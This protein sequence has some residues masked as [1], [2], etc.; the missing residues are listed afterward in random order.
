MLSLPGSGPPEWLES[1]DA[2]DDLIVSGLAWV[3]AGF[4]EGRW[5]VRRM[6]ATPALACEANPTIQRFTP[7]GHQLKLIASA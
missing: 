7:R 1:C 2:L 6:I 3:E 4:E 5:L